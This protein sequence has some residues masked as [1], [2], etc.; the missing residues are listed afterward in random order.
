LDFDGF[1]DTVKQAWESAPIIQDSG[2]MINAK[3]KR[4]R[5]SLKKW[6]KRVS[7]LKEIINNCQYTL[8]LLDGIEEQRNLSVV[9]KNFRRIVEIHTRKMLEAKRIYWK[10]R[11]KIKWAKLGDEIPNSSTLLLLN[12]I[13]EI[14]SPP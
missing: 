11:A 5:Y 12:N 7:N 8:A 3:F 10:S 4:T 2:K 13:E 14:L 6:S 9:E 1:Y